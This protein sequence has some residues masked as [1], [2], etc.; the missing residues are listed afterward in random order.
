MIPVLTNEYLN[1]NGIVCCYIVFPKNQLFTMIAVNFF[2]AIFANFVVRIFDYT[3][4][5]EMEGS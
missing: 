3:F 4:V 1:F 2:F 5:I